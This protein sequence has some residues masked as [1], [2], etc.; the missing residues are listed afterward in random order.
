MIRIKLWES[1]QTTIEHVHNQ[2]TLAFFE[3][4]LIE[5]LERQKG[6]EIRL[7]GLNVMLKDKE[8]TQQL[9]FF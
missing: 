8:V 4:L 2:L 9:S 7:I 6:R 5:V 3:E 1:N